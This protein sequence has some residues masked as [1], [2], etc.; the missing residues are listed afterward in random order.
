M[1]GGGVMRA[2]AAA[3]VIGITA[4]SGGFRGFAPDHPV[5]AAVRPVAASAISS[6]CD[7]VRGVLS[8]PDISAA[9][10]MSVPKPFLEFDDWGFSDEEET[11]PARLV[12]G[13]APTL[14]EA[15]E[16][17]SELKEAIDNLFLY[18][19]YFG[20]SQATGGD[21]SSSFHS[22]KTQGCDNSD[23]TISTHAT[24]RN[25]LQAFRLLSESA[26]AQSVVASIA[27]DPKVFAAVLEN[28][29]LMQFIEAHKSNDSSTG[30][31]L[32]VEDCAS[33]NGS[34]YLPPPRSTDKPAF[35]TRFADFF[36]KYLP[37]PKSSDDK[38][39]SR[40]K[41]ADFYNK[42]KAAVT[43]MMS[44]LSDYFQSIFGGDDVYINADGSAKIGAVEKTV[45]ASFLGLAIM[46]IMVFVLKQV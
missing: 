30:S 46:V 4:A 18:P 15:K 19:N 27:S 41:V 10:G 44:N 25:A 36:K 16:A 38:S 17:T 37:S 31:N 23:G 8:A 43:D 28:P 6:A 13:S 7:D 14:Q 12:F 29:E 2:A 20:C 1:G 35:Q 21:L 40:S 26:A 39:E 42:T 34:S 11:P 24:P 5:C 22:L 33:D 45:G 3:K 32:D 9:D